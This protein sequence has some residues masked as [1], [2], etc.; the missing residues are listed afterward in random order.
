MI[1]KT[2]LRKQVQK[3]YAVKDYL[4]TMKAEMMSLKNILPLQV[5]DGVIFS[6]RR[7]CYSISKK[8]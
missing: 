1:Y 7:K 5:E 8:T 4:S 3:F 6:K 2:V